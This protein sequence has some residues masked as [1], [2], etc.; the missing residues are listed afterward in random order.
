MTSSTNTPNTTTTS[1]VL[2]SSSFCVDAVANHFTLRRQFSQH[3]QYCT[4]MYGSARPGIDNYFLNETVGTK[5]ELLRA[6][7]GERD[8]ASTSTKGGYD[9]L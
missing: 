2:E 1:A 3:T 4:S 8:Q 9:G 5:A 7:Y 6:K